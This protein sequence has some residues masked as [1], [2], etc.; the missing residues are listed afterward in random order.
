V[1][2]K[3]RLS[4]IYIASDSEGSYR[5][6]CFSKVDEKTLYHILVDSLDIIDYGFF[7]YSVKRRASTLR[8]SSKEGRPLQS[9]VAILESYYVPFPKGV[10]EKV[11]Y[12][13][14]VEKKGTSVLF[15]VDD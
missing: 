11:V 3:Y 5:A 13:T 7:Y 4:N 10:V 14:G 6:W 9:C 8:T 1:Q 2:R 15:G 12:D